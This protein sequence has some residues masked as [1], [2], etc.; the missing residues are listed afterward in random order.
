MEKYF[1]RQPKENKEWKSK[2][3]SK[4]DNMEKQDRE[5]IKK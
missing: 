2:R 5:D 3:T 4:N 1:K